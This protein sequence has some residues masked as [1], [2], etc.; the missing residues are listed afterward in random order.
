MAFVESVGAGR[1]TYKCEQIY[2]AFI[3]FGLAASNKVISLYKLENI[4]FVTRQ[5]KISFSENFI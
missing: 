4:M 3:T 1:F 2:Q 5:R